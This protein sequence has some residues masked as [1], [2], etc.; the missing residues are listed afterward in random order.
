MNRAVYDK[1]FKMTAVK[2]AQSLDKSVNEAAQGLGI[3]GTTLRR[4]ID[5]YG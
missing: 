2:H 3:S 5:E 1:P 4:W